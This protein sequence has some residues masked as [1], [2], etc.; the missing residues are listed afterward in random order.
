MVS[1]A[2]NEVPNFTLLSLWLILVLVA[3]GAHSY[4]LL[5]LTL[6]E[7]LQVPQVLD[8]WDL[9]LGFVVLHVLLFSTLE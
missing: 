9:T 7:S 1:V 2:L 6:R 4:V 8:H 5:Y 3:C